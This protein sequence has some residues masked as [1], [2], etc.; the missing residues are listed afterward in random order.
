[1]IDL[2]M[3]SLLLRLVLLVLVWGPIGEMSHL[4]AFETRTNL[5]SPLAWRVLILLLSLNHLMKH[6]TILTL[7]LLWLLRL[8]LL[9]VLTSPLIRIPLLL[10]LRSLMDHLA[11]LVEAG[12]SVVARRLAL[13]GHLSLAIS[14]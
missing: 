11:L 13:K 5:G 12:A 3:T 1:M 9:P 2:S 14:F 8:H 6:L 4:V 10:V 7:L